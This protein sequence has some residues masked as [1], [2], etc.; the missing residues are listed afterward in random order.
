MINNN[1]ASIVL[2]KLF[3]DNVRRFQKNEDG[4]VMANT[5]YKLAVINDAYNVLQQVDFFE[6]K[7]KLESYDGEKTSFYSISNF[8]DIKVKESRS[9]EDLIVLGRFYLHPEL[10]QSPR[11]PKANLDPET[12]E[13]VREEREPFYLE[14]VESFTVDDLLNYFYLKHLMDPMP[15]R[16]HKTQMSNLA[17]DFPLDMILYLIDASAM[18]MEDDE[19]I[20]KQPARN[21]AF[22]NDF[23][24]EAR[25]LIDKRKNA[26]TEGGLTQIA[27]R[28][29]YYESRS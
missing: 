17:R 1:T 26:L 5:S 14:I 4:T 19:D 22:L 24:Q 10:Q 23:L 27:P 29:L 28:K 25:D 11:P 13:F 9:E 15:G 2:S 3:I 6:V 21:P 12:N 16:S 7:E 20:R 18:T 8:L